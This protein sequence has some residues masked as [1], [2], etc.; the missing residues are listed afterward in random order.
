MKYLRYLPFLFLATLFTF[1]SC[2]KDGFESEVIEKEEVTPKEIESNRLLSSER[3]VSTSNGLQLDCITISFPFD[4]AYDN[5][6]TITI[7]D[8]TDLINALEDTTNCCLVD[9]VYPLEVTDGDGQVTTVNNPEELGEL[10]A[11]CIPGGGWTENDFPAFLINQENSCYEF[12]YPIDLRD[13]D[14][15]TFTANNETEFIDLLADNPVL[16]F[17]FPVDLIDEDGATISPAD[18]EELF[19][20]LALC[21]EVHNPCD[22]VFF[23]D[24]IAC[25]T[26]EFPVS[27]LRA[28]SSVVT[29]N[30]ANDLNSL[31]L[32]G[33]IV[34]FVYPL[35]LIDVDGNTVTANDGAELSEL[36]DACYDGGI[37]GSDEAFLI[38]LFLSNIEGPGTGCYDINFPLNANL[39]NGTVREYA[40]LA[41]LLEP[42]RPGEASPVSVV[43]PVSITLN[44]DGTVVTLENDDD[45]NELLGVCQ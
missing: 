44:S 18:I 45:V 13:P 29:A 10:F 23:G 6:N 34:D 26:F 39:S 16:F 21:E 8:E 37:V 43:Y 2:E 24:Q 9:F 19:E 15:Q 41:E 1:T 27:F 12:S 11:S 35:N 22:S 20:A 7:N 3:T 28:D 31:F 5:G 32:G 17:V 4:L 38:L 14:G 25:Y 40:S 36:L 30:D 42:I 33:E